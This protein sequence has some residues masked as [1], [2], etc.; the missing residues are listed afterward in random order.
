VAL[1][2]YPRSGN[3]LLRGYLEK[4]MGLATGSGGLLSDLLIDKL[5]RGGFHGESITDHRVHIIKTH[6]PERSGKNPFLANRA[7]LL[8]R[9]PL[10]VLVSQFNMVATGSHHLSIREDDW[11]NLAEVFEQFVL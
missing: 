7:I 10:D 5:K 2:S 9:N 11:I 3:T 4:I 8:V 6:S 1:V